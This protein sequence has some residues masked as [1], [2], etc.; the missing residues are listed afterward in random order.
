MLHKLKLPPLG[1]RIIKSAIAV[2]LCFII[3]VIRGREGMPFYSAIG[4]LWCMQPYAGSTKSMAMQRTIG[5]IIGA[6]YGLVVIL[7]ELYIIPIHNTFA[8]Y[9]VVSFMIVVVLYTTSV[10]NKQNASYFSCV[11]FLSIT[12][13]HLTDSN[14]YLFVWNRFLDTMIGIAVG[15]LINGMDLPRKRKKDVLF[16]SG[17]DDTLLTPKEVLSPYSKIELNRMIERGA[18]F[19]VATMRTP[20]SL[21]EPLRDV[22]LK[23]PVIV[24]DGAALYDMKEK[25]YLLTYVISK[26]T[27]KKVLTF[28]QEQGFHTFINTITDNVLIIY[29]GKL[30]NEMEEKLMK[31]L[32]K[33]AYRNYMSMDYYHD[34]EVVYF[35]ILDQTDRVAK[36]NEQLK[37]EGFAEGLK[38]VCYPS[39]DYEGYSYIK[40]FNKNATRKH[41]QTYLAEQLDAKEIVTFGSLE[42][43]Y[44]IVIKDGDS[45]QVVKSMK[46]RFEPVYWK[47]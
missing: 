17:L 7:F 27:A 12:V 3:Y 36:L 19:T 30:Q 42:G 33:S 24:M 39:K 13:T 34:T 1:L 2:L 31:E 32:R 25:D 9:L 22:N 6:G 46:R 45:N 43:R 44:D 23:L 11:V 21:M 15:V 40:I 20:A 37:K 5:T 18:N 8:G 14:P 41:M 4:A 10:L 47:K 35:M 28:I 16:V 26:I 29:Y 38:I